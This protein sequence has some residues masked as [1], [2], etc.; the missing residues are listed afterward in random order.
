M[1][2]QTSGSTIRFERLTKRFGD[3]VAV[4]DVS[5]HVQKGEFLTLLGP[6]GSG[7][8]TILNM[9][10]GFEKPTEG[11]IYL[12]D[13][14]LTGIPPFKRNIGM[15]FQ[16]YALFPHMTVS[17]NIAFPLTTRRL[18][19]SQIEAM[20]KEAL[21]LV[22]LQGF[23]NRYPKQLSGGQQQRVALARSLIFKPPVLLM[24]EPLGALDK[25][26]REHM[27]LEIKHL[28]EELGFTAIYV[29]HDQSEALTMS[30]TV[31]LLNLGRLEQLGRPA[32]LY[33]K[34]RTRFVADFIGE[35]N[36]LEGRIVGREEGLV[37]I[38][39]PGGL[40]IKA[41]PKEDLEG[42]EVSISLRPEKVSLLDHGQQRQN[43]YRGTVG[44]IIYV[45]EATKLMILIEGKKEEV[46]LKLQNRKGVPTLSRGDS[47]MV[48]WDADDMTLF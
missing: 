20:V 22:K 24:D 7:K 26:L 30:D 35:T 29:T 27:Q 21:A 5:F 47:V 6:S 46:F 1:T 14:A 37:H 48:G 13:R 16:N 33:D 3:V 34:P 15:V 28:H 39:T 8:T 10:A 23:G 9:V 40:Q 42:E 31:A 25:K 12:D 2:R 17:E 45:G 11:N 18:P 19:K 4:S 41:V 43:S 32:E 36:L 38:R 44:G